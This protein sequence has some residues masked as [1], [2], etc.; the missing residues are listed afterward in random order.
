MVT[1]GNDLLEDK[2]TDYR[3]NSGFSSVSSYQRTGN[4]PRYGTDRPAN[5]LKFLIEVTSNLA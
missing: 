2:R 1:T 3:E 4:G 5:S